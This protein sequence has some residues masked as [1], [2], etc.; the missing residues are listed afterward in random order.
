MRG[1]LAV[2]TT[3]LL[4][5]NNTCILNIGCQS[6]APYVQVYSMFFYSMSLVA[7]VF[8]EVVFGLLE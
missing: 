5:D 8:R 3:M 4:I 7:A 2:S 1:W 6:D